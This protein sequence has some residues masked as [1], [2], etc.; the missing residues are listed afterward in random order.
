MKHVKIYLSILA[1]FCGICIQTSVFAQEST[2]I[3]GSSYDYVLL[4]GSS[5]TADQPSAKINLYDNRNKAVGAIS[6][7]KNNDLL[8][9]ASSKVETK[10]GDTK[11]YN[12]SYEFDMFEYFLTILESGKKVNIE[13]D[14]KSKKACVKTV[15]AKSGVTRNN[16]SSNSSIS[17]KTLRNG[18]GNSL[19]KADLLKR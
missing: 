10:L 16:G 18:K 1:F 17:S 14:T 19:K 15:K 4:P 6:F 7:Y 3:A 8:K 5:E 13:Y 12:V 11:T 2:T 9:K